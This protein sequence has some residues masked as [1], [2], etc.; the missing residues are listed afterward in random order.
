[1]MTRVVREA[2]CSGT[3]LLSN[4][5]ICNKISKL[6]PRSKVQETALQELYSF[7]NLLVAGTVVAATELTIQWNGIENVN[8]ISSAGQT[9]PMI[10]GIGLIVRVV[11]IALFG[12]LDDRYRIREGPS[13]ITYVPTLAR[14]TARP[15]ASGS[16][17]SL[18]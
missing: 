1:M 12:D 17:R 11:Y 8:G 3:T 15:E 6:R 5:T 4:P 2:R 13:P 16:S 9:I 14:M 10:I 7:F 18:S